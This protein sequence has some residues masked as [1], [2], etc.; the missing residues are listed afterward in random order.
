[1]STSKSR[2]LYFA[3]LALLVS[4][5]GV[6]EVTEVDTSESSEESAALVSGSRVVYV[7]D[8]L[9]YETA[10]VVRSRLEAK[11]AI[12]AQ[13]ARG[14]MAICD[15]FPE[16]KETFR[17]WGP[18]APPN[19]HDLVV[20]AKPHVVVM[21]FWGNSWQ[22]T[23]CMKDSAGVVLAQGTKGYYDRYRKD[24]NRAMEVIRDAAAK[25]GI[26]MPKVMWVLQGPDSGNASRPKT[27]NEMYASLKS[28]WPTVS[29]IDAGKTVSLAANYWN[30]G[31]R[32]G[33][34]RYL[35][36]TKEE[37][38]TGHCVNAYG[39][40]ARIHSDKDPLHFCLGTVSDKGC[41][42]WSPG[43][44]RYAGAIA[45]AVVNTLNK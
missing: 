21:Q 8:S 14:G 41:D 32:Y 38:D 4:A 26:P 31:D 33:W 37:R 43:I 5:C 20:F 7:G 17:A 9:A 13:A 45:N 25:A 24:A 6:S 22:Y 10:P 28:K 42:T 18:P 44:Y 27:L 35:P 15:Y 11:G 3:S 2:I 16:T 29:T 39:G 30:P 34:S 12:F 23:P 19:L 1:M 36:C 40:V